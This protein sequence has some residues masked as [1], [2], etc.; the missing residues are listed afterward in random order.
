[1]RIGFIGV[2]AMGAPMAERLIG[3]GHDVVVFD[4][5]DASAGP[6][7]D[8]G[9]A[10]ARTPGEA[11]AGTYVVFGCLP[12]PQV[13]RAVA[14]GPDGVARTDGVSA[15][16]E[17]STIGSATVV[18]IARAMAERGVLFLDAPVSG[19]PKGARA[20]TLTTM[21]AG[22]DEAFSHCEAALR[23][24]A[25]NVFH[26]GKAPGQG[27][28]AKLANNMIS[29]AAMVASFEAVT[30][31]VKAGIDADTLVDLINVSTGRSGATLDKFPHA[32]LP[33]T[34]DYGGK[35]GTMYK[36]V[37]LCLEE[38]R[39]RAVPHHVSS[40][41]AQIW[42]QGMAEGRSDDD[43]TSLIKVIENWAGVEVRGKAASR[44]GA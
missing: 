14:L 19:G 34:F 41:V 33:R 9:A 25:A 17:M 18:E 24:I 35:L 30:M 26:V 21:V 42:F 4:P 43:Y 29:A 36:D 10:R 5:S 40:S 15:Y 8:R 38:Y 37:M 12:N 20:G 2:G 7:V 32:I 13:S 16:V 28:V 39:N 6:L 1:M 31:G 23:T 22:S 3:A 11:A 44:A 27:Q